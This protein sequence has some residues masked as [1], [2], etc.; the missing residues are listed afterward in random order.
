MPLPLDTGACT[1]G[2]F[3]MTRMLGSCSRTQC[4]GCENGNVL[5][6]KMLLQELCSSKSAVVCC[7]DMRV[8]NAQFVCLPVCIRLCNSNRY[9]K[10]SIPAIALPEAVLLSHLSQGS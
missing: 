5:F 3:P 10:Q 8:Y 7:W 9:T 2:S 4:V 6:L 1:V